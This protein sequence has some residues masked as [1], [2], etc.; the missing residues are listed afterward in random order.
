VWRGFSQ[1]LENQSLSDF[2]AS[3]QMGGSRLA[4]A[5]SRESV[6]SAK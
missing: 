6:M 5:A 2:V 1:S 3:K 4:E